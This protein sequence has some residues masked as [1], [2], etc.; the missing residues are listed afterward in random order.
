[1]SYKSSI[2]NKILYNVFY[3]NNIC[4]ND[5]SGSNFCSIQYVNNN[6]SNIDLTNQ[7]NQLIQLQNELNDIIPKLNILIEKNKLVIGSI[8]TT[9]LLIPPPNYLFCDG[10]SLLVSQYQQLFNIIGYAYGGSGASFNLP[11]FRNCY[12][13]GGNNNINNIS[14]SNL[15]SGNGSTGATNN[16]AISYNVFPSTFPLLTV[17][18]QHIHQ[19]NDPTHG[20]YSYSEDQPYSDIGTDPFVKQA[21][22]DGNFFTAPA[23]TGITM[24]TTGSNI[25]QKDNISNLS[26][27][28]ITPAFIS[29][30]F[31]ICVSNN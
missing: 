12:I 1:M 14:V 22:G 19:V 6:I 17:I 24:Q 25:Q 7:T 18:N 4:G 5:L 31:I 15:F 29:C 13:L 27:V 10:A 21:N 26:G 3:N 30:T 2:N 23:F 8:T 9:I 20:H 28:N 11:D 16:Y